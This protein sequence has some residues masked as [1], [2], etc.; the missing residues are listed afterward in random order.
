M[1]GKV[2]ISR[3]SEEEL[4]IYRSRPKKYQKSKRPVDWRWPQN[5]RRNEQRANRV[6]TENH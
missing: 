1:N 5:R 6:A 2:I 4:A 3:L